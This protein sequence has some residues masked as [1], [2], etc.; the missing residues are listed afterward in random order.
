MDIGLQG[1]CFCRHS[2][3][4]EESSKP[5]ASQPV[6]PCLT[7]NLVALKPCRG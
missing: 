3:N 5:K 7:R 4:S 6:I 1:M 2:E